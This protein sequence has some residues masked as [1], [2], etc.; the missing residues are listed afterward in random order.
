MLLRLLS[1][2]TS[3]LMSVLTALKRLWIG[4]ICIQFFIISTA[5]QLSHFPFCFWIRFAQFFIRPLMSP[6]ATIREI[7]AVDSGNCYCC[8]LYDYALCVLL[9]S[10]DCILIIFFGFFNPENQKKLLSDAWRMNQ[11][12]CFVSSLIIIS[13]LLR[14]LMI[15]NAQL[16]YFLRCLCRTRQ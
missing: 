6:D 7:K 14:L 16:V 1:T 2:Q 10:A 15:F 11:V 4:K 5:S 3:I 9:I 13:S 12:T 8:S